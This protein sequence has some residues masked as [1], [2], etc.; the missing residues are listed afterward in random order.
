MWEWATDKGRFEIFGE[1][2]Q[3][4]WIHGM[5]SILREIGWRSQADHISLR[6]LNGIQF[7]DRCKDI[8][9]CIKQYAE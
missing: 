9:E 6:Y 2:R 7:Q 5:L 3:L 1:N 8:I 4:F